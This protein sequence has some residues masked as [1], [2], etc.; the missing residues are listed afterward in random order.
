MPI[1][2]QVCIEVNSGSVGK[3]ADQIGLV[4]IQNGWTSYIAFARNHRPSQSILIRIGSY[5]D[6]Y[7]HGIQTRIFDNHGLCSKRA[8]R[9]LINRIEEIKPDIIHLHHLHGYYINI[10]ILFNYLSSIS[11][12]VVWSFVDC[13]SM[14]GHCCHFDFVGCYK[15]MDECNKCPQKKEYPASF[16]IDRSKTNFYLKKKLFLS[17]KNITIVSISKWLDDIVG[18]SFLSSLNRQVIFGALNTSLFNPNINNKNIRSEYNIGDKFMIL[19]VASPWSRKKG[20]YD[21][22]QLSRLLEDDT[23]LVII[24]LNKS[25]LKKIPKN[26][27]GLTRTE[28][29]EQLRDFYATSDVYMNLSVEETFGMTTAEAMSCG[30]P[31]IVYN[32]TASPELID[33]KTG[34][35]VEKADFISLLDAISMVKKNGK[36]YYAENCRNRAFELFNYKDRYQEY[37]ALYT[38]LLN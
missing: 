34:I 1:L 25:Q 16:F 29:Q 24:G 28:N 11:T 9:K 13:W 8:T 5:F 38:K 22:I 18:K 7:W 33:N 37:I 12:P 3:I 17:V 4:A 14:T 2:F 20:F 30:T 35:L 23:I 10:E 15:W 27:I 21:F 6:V 19:G 36:D 26:I 32:S 31:V